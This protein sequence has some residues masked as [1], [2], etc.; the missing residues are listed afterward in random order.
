MVYKMVGWLDKF[1]TSY[2]KFYSNNH[3]LLFSGMH[4]GV[5]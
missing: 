1:K 4:R 5:A 3:K 2:P